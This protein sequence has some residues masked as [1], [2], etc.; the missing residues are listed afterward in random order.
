MYHYDY[1][2]GQGTYSQVFEGANI[3]TE[4]QVAI[5]VIDLAMIK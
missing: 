2:I 1:Q 3:K 4:K 5:K